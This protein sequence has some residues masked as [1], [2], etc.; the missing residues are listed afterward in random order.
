MP[1]SI[2]ESLKG[3]DVLF[4]SQDVV[5]E[6]AGIQ[7]IIELTNRVKEIL[8]SRFDGRYTV[9]A[10]PRDKVLYGE[11]Q[12]SRDTIDSYLLAETLGGHNWKIV[13]G[14]YSAPLSSHI[15]KGAK[16]I[17]LVHLWKWTKPDIKHYWMNKLGDAGVFMPENM[18]E[19]EKMLG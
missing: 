15:F 7:D 14:Y 12:K 16:V 1:H 8:D 18:K 4:L 3:K 9:K 6:G 17:S 5:S 10:H 11:M 13:I 2:A 19:F